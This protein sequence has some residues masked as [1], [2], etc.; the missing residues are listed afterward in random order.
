MT[1]LEKV[2]RNAEKIEQ[3]LKSALE[4]EKRLNQ[5]LMGRLDTYQS[6][7]ERILRLLIGK[8]TER[9]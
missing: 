5:Q 7:M 3:N 1:E 9:T 2:K 6:I 4:C 8:A